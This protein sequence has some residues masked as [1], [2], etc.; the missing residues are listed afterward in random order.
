M[1]LYVLGGS[2]LACAAAHGLAAF[3]LPQPTLWVTTRESEG[4]CCGKCC[5]FFA[6]TY[7]RVPGTRR[8]GGQGLQGVGGEEGEEEGMEGIEGHEE[9]GDIEEGGDEGVVEVNAATGKVKVLADAAGDGDKGGGGGS[10][11]KGKSGETAQRPG[12]GKGGGKGDAT[13]DGKQYSTLE[14]V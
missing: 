7:R 14:K 6:S 11:L 4:G 9:G 5:S 8:R 13:F 1:T 3:A 2:S 12:G 10:D